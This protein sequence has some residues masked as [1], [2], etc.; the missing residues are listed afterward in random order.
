MATAYPATYGARISGTLTAAAAAIAVNNLKPISTI[1]FNSTTS[2]TIQLSLDGG[3]TYYPAV[4]PT[5]TESGQIY[6]VLNFP[7]TN[8]KFNGAIA[9]TWTVL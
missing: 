3:T 7:V 9:D 5:G 8:I 1:V 2:P 6:Y 4:T